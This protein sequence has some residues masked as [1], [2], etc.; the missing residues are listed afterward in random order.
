VNDAISRGLAFLASRQES[1]GCWSDWDDLPVGPS[2]MW[3]TAYCGWRLAPCA[4]AWLLEPAADWLE[5]HELPGG[6][7]GYAEST[8]PDA[9][10]TALGILF[11]HAIG[12]RPQESAIR[13]L[14]S[15]ARENGGFA[16]YGFDQAFGSWTT[17]H[18]EV[19]A[20]AALALRSA[21]A[22]HEAVQRATHFVRQQRRSDGLW[23]SYWWIS[24]WYATEVALRLLGGPGPTAALS[25]QSC[26]ETALQ[27]LVTQDT[28]DQ[29]RAAQNPDGSWPSAPILRLTDRDK[30]GAGLLFADPQRVFTTATVISALTGSTR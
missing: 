10:S 7:W 23:D 13:R 17:S 18:V 11:Q 15:F 4:P 29:L 26:F 1:S 20:T 27:I 3:T 19:T 5:A 9:D 8:G 2:R 21:G 16:T 24:P 28:A 12:R 6:G 30:Y 25:P 22:A 14:L